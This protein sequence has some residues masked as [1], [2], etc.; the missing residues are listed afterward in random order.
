MSNLLFAELM[1][2][3][4]VS[5]QYLV[6]YCKKGT[7]KMGNTFNK[8]INEICA[9]WGFYAAYSP[10]RAYISLTSPRKPETKTIIF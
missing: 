1:K 2:I 3:S 4:S 8:T 6:T 7:A 5:P 9:L 10:E